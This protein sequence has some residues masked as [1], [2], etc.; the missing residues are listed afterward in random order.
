MFRR[1]YSRWTQAEDST[2][3]SQFEKYGPAYSV[4]RKSMPGRS[5]NECQRRISRLTLPTEIHKLHQSLYLAGNER[6]G[7]EWYT[8]PIDQVG[9]KPCQILSRMIPERPKGRVKV[10]KNW[11][12][13]EDLTLKEAY[14]EFGAEWDS[15]QRF[16]P[17]RTAVQC[18]RRM[19][20]MYARTFADEACEN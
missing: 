18:Q 15:I 4:I 16:L 14:E 2:L 5:V 3:L 13:E 9:S 8:F 1:L 17:F 20:E 7:E 11:K 19:E 6:I 12:V 10:S